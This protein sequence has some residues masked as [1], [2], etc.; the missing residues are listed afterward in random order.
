MAQATLHLFLLLLASSH[1]CPWHMRRPRVTSCTCVHGTPGV[2]AWSMNP[3]L[4]T[5]I[6]RLVS[7]VAKATIPR[8]CPPARGSRL[9]LWGWVGPCPNLFEVASLVLVYNV[10]PAVSG[11]VPWSFG[12]LSVPVCTLFLC[13]CFLYFESRDPALCVLVFCVCLH[14]CSHTLVSH[15]PQVPFSHLR[16]LLTT[17]PPWP[18][19]AGSL[20]CVWDCG[21]SGRT[22]TYKIFRTA[23]ARN[24]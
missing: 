19:R 21:H 7:S 4:L 14:L 11:S 16:A 22:T 12:V 20:C 15:L 3:W 13:V 9:G 5:P 10:N 1:R 17:S 23:M 24:G 18:R 8:L 2:T 6:S